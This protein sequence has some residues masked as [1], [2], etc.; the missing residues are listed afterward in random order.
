MEGHKNEIVA[1]K[2]EELTKMK[3]LVKLLLK[4]SIE[5]QDREHRIMEEK[6]QVDEC[7]QK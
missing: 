3:E 1:D 6:C 7:I 2:R 5:A 4:K